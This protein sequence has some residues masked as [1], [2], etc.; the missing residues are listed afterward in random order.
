[1]IK[2]SILFKPYPITS[3]LHY[4]KL[5]LTLPPLNPPSCMRIDCSPMVIAYILLLSPAS[6]IYQVIGLGSGFK[7]ALSALP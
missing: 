2:I 7:T 6:T 1:M 3:P 5:T 4:P